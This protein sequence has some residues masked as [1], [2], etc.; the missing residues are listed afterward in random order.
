MKIFIPILFVTL[1]DQDYGYLLV[2]LLNET[3]SFELREI[4]IF[5]FNLK[6]LMNQYN[7]NKIKNQNL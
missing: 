7:K 1:N 5:I 4:Y 2:Y 3:T 6:I